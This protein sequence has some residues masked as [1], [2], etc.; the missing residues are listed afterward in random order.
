MATLI[1]AWTRVEPTQLQTVVGDFLGVDLRNTDPRAP[2]SAYGL[3]SLKA[4]EIVAVLEEAYGCRLP[5]SLL[6]ECPDIATLAEEL[7][8]ILQDGP[9]DSSRPHATLLADAVLP[10]DIQPATS[11]PADG[12]GSRALLTGATGFLG[13]WLIRT[14]LDETTVDVVCLVRPSREVPLDRIQKNLE[15]YG[16]WRSGDR[17][18]LFAIDGDLAQ[19]HLGLGPEAFE[20]LATEVGVIYHAGADVNWAAPYDGLAA[21]NVRG[22]TELLRLACRGV[23]KPFRFVSS[24]SVCYAVDGPEVVTERMDMLPFADRLPLGYAQSKCVAEA[25]VRE[26]ARRGLPATIFRPALIAGD[27]STGASNV[28]DLVALLLK[29]CIDMRAAPDLDWTFDAIPVDVAARA[30]VRLAAPSS[31]VSA[32]LETFHLQHP[33]PRHW[34]ECVLWANLFGYPMRL[35]PY[36][37][38]LDRLTRESAKAGHPLHRLRNFFLRRVGG[39]TTPEHYQAHVHSRIDVGCAR[40]AESAH[41]ITYPPLDAD[42]L[43]RYFNEYVRRGH[44]PPPPRNSRAPRRGAA[45]TWQSRDHFEQLLRAHFNDPSLR[46]ARVEPLSRGSDHSIVGELTSWRRG[47]ATGLFQYRI[48]VCARGATRTLEVMVKAKPSDDDVL[49]VAETTAAT[50]DERVSAAFRT[51]RE[52][53]G[54][55][56]SHVRE[57]AIYEDSET[58]FRRY[59]PRCYGT[60]RHD[61]EASWGIVMERLTG[62][63]VMNASDT[64]APWTDGVIRTV[65][66][67]LADMQAVWLGREAELGRKPW[68]GPVTSAES[69]GALQPFWRA[70]ADHAAPAFQRWG[71]TALVAAHAELVRTAPIWWRVLDDHPK[72]LIHHD[73]NPRNIGVRRGSEGLR[74]VAY[75]WELATI[76][77]PQRDLAEFL[78]FV[79]PDDVSRSRLDGYIETHRCELER[80]AMRPLD[81]RQW[82]A[83]FATALADVLVARLSFYALIDRVRQQSFLPRVVR[84]WRRLH[85]LCAGP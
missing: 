31:D 21:A 5:E 64:L 62:M 28:E 63:E 45:V 25:L 37:V 69:A 53:V 68:I 27:S 75:D 32:S 14:L 84:T 43:N 76:S 1:A 49:D 33:R 74:L 11:C 77:A 19:E 30:I 82:R 23:P 70:L 67:G 44:L 6:L 48:D 3:D 83:A 72:T 40:D 41:G 10:A 81:A 66:G 46:V 54:V 13:A 26:A 2:L 60:W 65:I 52:L 80:I 57:L 51:V 22:T 4:L 78:C 20:A 50:C 79:L 85:E 35:E 8:R 15:R 38:W 29:G 12:A 34:R 59:L 7:Q 9:G 24:L 73:F 17:T 36:D 56:G 39:R 71:G 58:R 47:H 61:E 42:L 16:L 18:R 55:R